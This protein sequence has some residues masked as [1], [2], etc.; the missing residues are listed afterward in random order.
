MKTN[1]EHSIFDEVSTESSNPFWTEHFNPSPIF[2]TTHSTG[3][4]P[5]SSGP[6]L[7]ATMITGSGASSIPG[8]SASVASSN[9]KMNLVWDATVKLTGFQASVSAAAQTLAN[10][11]TDN[12]TVNIG[13][14]NSGTGG[15][16]A[17]GPSAGLYKS[18]A[19]TYGKL[20]ANKSVGDITFNALPNTTSIQ[21]QANVA[22]WN[23]QL[24]L[25]G[26]L[27]PTATGLDASA[28][29]ATDIA[30][31]ALTGV[32]LHELHHAL[33]GVP[34]GTAPDVFD[35]F[36]FTAPGKM[37]FTSSIPSPLAYFSIDGGITKLAYFGMGSDPSDFYNG[38][39]TG[40]AKTVYNTQVDAFSEYY[41]SN[42]TTYGTSYQYLSAAD[43]HLMDAL[44]YH[45]ASLNTQTVSAFIASAS[46]TPVVIADTNTAILS[47][48]DYLNTNINKI[49]SISATDS[50]SMLSVS[51]AQS[52]NDQSVLMLMSDYENL[53]LNV[54]GTSSSETLYG[55]A[56]TDTVNGGG[57]LDSII[58]N[59][60]TT[61]DTIQFN[62]AVSTANTT[63]LDK[64]TGFL[65]TDNVQ[66]C[67][68]S[69]S[70]GDLCNLSTGALI[71]ANTV[72][73]SIIQTVA[74]GKAFTA[75]SL[76]G[77][78]ILD[79]TGKTYASVTAL[80]A[81]LSSTTGTYATFKANLN[82]GYHFLAE[83]GATDGL[84][85]AEIT[86]GT[87]SNHLINAKG[88]DLVD[89]I[90][91]TQHLTAAHLS[92]VAA[93]SSQEIQ[94]PKEIAKTSEEPKS[95]LSVKPSAKSLTIPKKKTPVKKP[96][97]KKSGNKKDQ[98]S[99]LFGQ[100]LELHLQGKLKK[101][102]SL[103]QE[104]LKVQ[105]KYFDAIHSMG[106]IASQ[107]G[108]FAMAIKLFEQAITIDPKNPQA[109]NNIANSL[110]GV[111]K[112][113]DALAHF[114]TAISLEPNYAEAFNNRGILLRS[115][116]GIKE[117]IE[118]YDKAISLNPNFAEAY[119]NRGN[120]FVETGQ[121]I[122]ALQSYD[123]AINLN[124]DHAAA[125]NN[126]G[127]I[128]RNLKQ[129]ELALKNFDRA[130]KIY[131][132]YADA[133]NNRGYAMLDL[134][135][136]ARALASFEKALTLKPKDPLALEGKVLAKKAGK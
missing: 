111:G 14:T 63:N 33:G 2:F 12:I 38:T 108:D 80:I 104:I 82:N 97:A 107:M 54:V 68:S 17:A 15:G 129:S 61:S 81:D 115:L 4:I 102:W 98:V 10:A 116:N 36:R 83:Y 39:P 47:N 21:S 48:L 99:I 132:K 91:V 95:S 23:A 71:A 88:F 37:L 96:A 57:G 133:Y 51:A 131:P 66:L 9:F 60:H 130:I 26:Y 62:T 5:V 79:V 124:S 35:L 50:A 53:K 7:P 100:A 25:W 122:Q 103:Y 73:A 29:F 43:L 6:I 101:A 65:A 87:T 1:Y 34:Y 59:Y 90:G 105:P 13:I 32:V 109:H 74:G 113:V 136:Y 67:N 127:V 46:T 69:D 121:L 86:Q 55:V 24:K 42:S 106:L 85:I 28:T 22:V 93:Q 64:V 8:S 41:Y 45:L 84:H 16:A 114:D 92:I 49:Y 117:A 120:A 126:R 134:K 72:A 27:S 11:L 19:S 89:L 70:L 20:I 119:F 56:G 118:S 135:Q 31:N 58:L 44:G 52:V 77:A 75:G 128:L 110:S 76:S 3:Q 40:G 78:D 112:R 123:S 94:M 125:L 18:Y 30:A